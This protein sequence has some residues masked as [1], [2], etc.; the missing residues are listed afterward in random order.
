MAFGLS[1]VRRALRIIA[2]LYGVKTG[3]QVIT[4]LGAGLPPAVIVLALAVPAGLALMHAALSQLCQRRPRTAAYSALVLFGLFEV[5]PVLLMPALLAG[6]I[7]FKAIHGLC[8]YNGVREA[9]ALPAR[10]D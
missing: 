8:L 10:T 4:V 1:K 2:G 7:F 3:W 6:G 9:Q 5:L